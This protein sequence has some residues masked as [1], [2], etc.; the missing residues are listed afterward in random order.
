MAEAARLG[1]TTAIVPRAAVK[2]L[3]A[4]NG[5]RLVGVANLAQAARQALQPVTGTPGGGGV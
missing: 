5:L 2:S 4:P 3:K 1:F